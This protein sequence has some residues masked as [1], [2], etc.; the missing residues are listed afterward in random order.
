MKKLAL[1]VVAPLAAA[2]AL[3]QTPAAGMFLVA[4]PQLPDPQFAESVV[5]I[6][7]HD[8]EGAVG[9]VVNRPTWVAPETLFPDVDF[10]RRHRGVV[11]FGGPVA[12]TSALF[13]MRDGGGVEGEP[14]VDDIHV[15]ANIDE[16]RDNLPARTDGRTLR[17]YAGYAGWGPGQLGREIAAGD[18]QVAPASADLIF[19]PEP[20]GLWREVHRVAPDMGIV[21]LPGGPWQGPRVAALP[22][23]GCRDSR[24]A[25]NSLVW[26]QAGHS[27]PSASVAYTMLDGLKGFGHACISYFSSWACWR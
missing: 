1:S 18:W 6:L 12:R 8:H 16:V 4:T 21:G 13:L 25:R 20:A 10:F 26:R 22:H 27:P 24:N 15:T 17:V 7:N 19:T 9:V 23:C 14:I 5:L 11:Y 3:A 2:G